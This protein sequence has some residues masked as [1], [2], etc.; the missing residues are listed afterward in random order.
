MCKLGKYGSLWWYNGIPVYVGK[1]L[2][3]H[4]ELVKWYPWNWVLFILALPIIIYKLTTKESSDT[5]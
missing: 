4:R 3:T 5:N 1:I 2:I